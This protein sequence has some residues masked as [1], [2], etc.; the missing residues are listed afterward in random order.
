MKFDFSSIDSGP[1]VNGRTIERCRAEIEGPAKRA[2]RAFVLPGAALA[3][4][5]DRAGEGFQWGT[6]FT[7]PRGA[8]RAGRYSYVG[9]HFIANGPVLIGDLCMISSHVKLFGDDHLTDV[10]GGPPR[11][12]LNRA[13]RPVT[14]FETDCWI[15]MGAMIREGVRIG[16][17]AV[18]AAGAVVTRSVAPYDIVA[19]SPAKT[20]RARFDAAQIATHEAALFG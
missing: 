1:P 19:G 5:L 4:G 20:I 18:V 14:V 10:V 16:R 12:E 8:V 11:V 15:G 7:A 3:L 2:L 6:P 9:A 17:G 13:D